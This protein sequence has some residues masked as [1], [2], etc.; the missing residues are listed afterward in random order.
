MTVDS[1]TAPAG[2]STLTTTASLRGPDADL[3]DA[4]DRRREAQLAFLALP[5]D[6]NDAAVNLDDQVAMCETFAQL[7]LAS[8]LRGV[9]IQLWITLSHLVSDPEHD[10][11][12]YIADIEYFGL[13]EKSLDW[14]ARLVLAAIQSLR[15][16]GGAA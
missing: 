7:A 1:T 13:I 16:M 4:F 10:R 5:N 6:G 12:T 3:I 9:E 15:A 11:R 14:P 8:T 2:A